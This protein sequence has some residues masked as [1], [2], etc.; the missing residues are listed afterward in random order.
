MSREK[1]AIRAAAFGNE[2]LTSECCDATFLELARIEGKDAGTWERFA[3][4][5]G[6][7]NGHQKAITQ[8]AIDMSRAYIKVV[9]DNFANAVI[10][11]D[12]F[13]VVSQASQAVEEVRRKEARQ[14][15]MVIDLS[16]AEL[17]PR[18]FPCGSRPRDVSA[19]SNVSG[20]QRPSR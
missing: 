16:C 1:T 14:D 4:Q 19:I 20:S 12:K 15:S 11:Y 9:K 13:H 10:V 3:E 6:K 2:L 18:P 17:K 8:V 7:H 5:L